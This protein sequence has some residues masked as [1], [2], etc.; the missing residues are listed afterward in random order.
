MSERRVAALYESLARFQWWRARRG[1]DEASMDGLEMRKR[2]LPSS[3]GDRPANGGSGLDAWL[4]D[5]AGGCEGARLVDL[6]CGFGASMLRAADAGASACV[7]VTPSA[8]QA[9]RAQQVARARGVAARCRFEVAEV[10]AAL[11][12]ADVVL[13]VESL[14][15]THDLG[16]ALTQVAASLQGGRRGAFVWL[17]DLLLERS[18]ADPDVLALA[19]AWASPPLRSLS[20]VDEAVARAGLVVA[21]SDDLTS[22]VARRDVAEIDRSR[23]ALAALRAITPWPFARRILAAFLGGLHLERLY[24]RGLACYRL[25]LAHPVDQHPRNP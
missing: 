15:H 20:E 10:S 14:G 3:R 17:E 22:Q 2:L 16:A 12:A 13:A 9:A 11:P 7:G 5:V 19:R 25:V 6:G 4:R 24:A 21:R 18:D 8:Y 1:L 23:R